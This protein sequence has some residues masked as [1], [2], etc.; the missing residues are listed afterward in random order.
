[1]PYKDPTKRREC[2]RRSR[3][4]NRKRVRAYNKTW[5][6]ANPEKIAAAQRRW[7]RKN[8]LKMLIQYAERRAKSAG[9]QFK[10]STQDLVIPACCPWLGIPLK[11]DGLMDNRPTIDRVNNK[12]GYVP[13][14]V[15]VISWRANRLKN[16][17]TLAELERMGKR[18]G[19]MSR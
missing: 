17:A 4:R 19:K 8:Y 10:I 18:A 11:I 16:N 9:L 2:Q 14:N 3:E 1:M 15:E 7:R 6:K 13:N 12:K 5:A